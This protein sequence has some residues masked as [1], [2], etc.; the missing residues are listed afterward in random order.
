M[1]HPFWNL[2]R[3][4]RFQEVVVRILVSFVPFVEKNEGLWGRGSTA[5]KEKHHRRSVKMSGGGTRGPAT[6]RGR[7]HPATKPQTPT[8]PAS[9]NSSHY[10]IPYH[11]NRDGRVC[12]EKLMSGKDLGRR[13]KPCRLRSRIG[14]RDDMICDCGLRL[15][16]RSPSYT[17]SFRVNLRNPCLR[18]PLRT[19]ASSV[20]KHLFR[21]VR[22]FRG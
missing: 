18:I 5:P 9:T 1:S 12:Q 8:K 15:P 6:G 16:R 22:V 10:I 3:K 4:A 2:R 11:V 17:D 19:S 21:V 13:R 20:V 14:V 7:K